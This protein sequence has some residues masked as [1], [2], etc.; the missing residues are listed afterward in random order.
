MLKETVDESC[1]ETSFYS[2]FY[3]F[4]TIFTINQFTILR[5]VTR[6]QFRFDQRALP[7]QDG[8]PG[9]VLL[10]RYIL[11]L[12]E[13]S[14]RCTYESLSNWI[15]DRTSSIGEFF[16]LTPW[17]DFDVWQRRI[18]SSFKCLPNFIAAILHQLSK[19]TRIIGCS[20]NANSMYSSPCTLTRLGLLRLCCS[21]VI[22]PLTAGVTYIHRFTFRNSVAG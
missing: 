4:F 7:D 22:R 6:V 18:R 20:D 21:Y 2:S 19:T 12:D 5:T 11:C 8:K 15:A 3:Y 14:A 16:Y 10:Q 1:D 17:L 13:V 9:V